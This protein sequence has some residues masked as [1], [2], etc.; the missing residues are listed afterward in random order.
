MWS[1]VGPIQWYWDTSQAQAG[2]G[3]AEGA[4]CAPPE[5]SKVVLISIQTRKTDQMKQI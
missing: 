3:Q 4:A 1:Q 2:F 5:F